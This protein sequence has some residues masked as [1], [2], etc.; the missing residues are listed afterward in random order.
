MELDQT[1]LK[2]KIA[3]NASGVRD[4][5]SKSDVG[6]SDRFKKLIDQLAGKDRSLLINRVQA[7]RRRRV[8]TLH[9]LIS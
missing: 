2:D 7:S 1:K 6:I 5:L 3:E 4:F 9:A 8:R